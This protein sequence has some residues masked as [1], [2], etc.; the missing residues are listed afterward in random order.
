MLR[1]GETYRQQ[2]IGR[3]RIV[4]VSETTVRCKDGHLDGVLFIGDADMGLIVVVRARCAGAIVYFCE[5]ETVR[6]TLAGD[7]ESATGTANQ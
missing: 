7:G 2:Q 5:I 1:N 6:I 4:Y 3:T